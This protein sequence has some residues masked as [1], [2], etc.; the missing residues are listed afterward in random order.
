MNIFSY[1]KRCLLL[2]LLSI[3]FATKGQAYELIIPAF[4]YRTGPYAS[5]GIPFWTGFSDYLTLLNERDGGIGGVKL[6]I[7]PCETAY[8]TARGAACYEKIKAS[9]LAVIAGSTGIAYD[10]IPKGAADRIPILSPGYGRTSSADGRVFKW[11]FNFPATYWSGASIII[12]Y[13]A[14][15]NGGAS[16]LRGK[17]IGLLYLD[18][19]YGREPIPVLDALAAKH[20]FVFARYAA[21]PPGEDLS[22]VWQKIDEDR[23]DWLLL[24]GYGNM[25]QAAVSDAI[26]HHFPLDRLVGNWWASGENDVQKAGP[27]ADGYLGAALHAPGAVCPVHEAIAKYVYDAGK[28]GDSGFRHRIGEVLYNRGLVQ[29]MWLA[30]GIAKAMELRGKKEIGPEDVRDGLEALDVDAGRLEELGFEGMIA[31]LKLSCSNHEG[32]GRA[33]IQQWDGPGQRWRLVSGFYE[34]DHDLID[35]LLKQDSERYAKEHGIPIRECP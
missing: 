15:Q 35:P 12:K 11:A 16:S 9:A 1:G 13:I 29:A 32:P 28:A 3:V 5:S 18:N 2:C 31:P 19:A 20:G 24:W 25:N 17:T 33:A 21:K 22:A 4:E 34:P 8:D 27:A 14:D 23:P 30:E 7:V 10:L 26:L 6:K